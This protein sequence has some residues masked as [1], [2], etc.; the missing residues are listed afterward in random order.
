MGEVRCLSFT[1]IISHA[2]LLATSVAAAPVARFEFQP[3][4]PAI[5]LPFLGMSAMPS[6]V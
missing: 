5:S 2:R 1:R 4:S 3:V 6:E